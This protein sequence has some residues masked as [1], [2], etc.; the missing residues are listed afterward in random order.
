M[1]VAQALFNGA[2][3]LPG[4]G[5]CLFSEMLLCLSPPFLWGSWEGQDLAQPLI[6]AK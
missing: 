6:N 4:T 2:A 5:P 3:S 1:N